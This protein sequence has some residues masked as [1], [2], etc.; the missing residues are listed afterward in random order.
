MLR[1][2]LTSMMDHMAM[3]LSAVQLLLKGMPRA[4]MNWLIGPSFIIM[5]RQHT[6]MATIEAT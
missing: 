3:P 4:M 1:H 6:Q 2:T 5:K